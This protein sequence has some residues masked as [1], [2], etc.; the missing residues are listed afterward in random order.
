[1]S[2]MW[3]GWQGDEPLVDEEGT[4]RVVYAPDAGQ[5]RWLLGAYGADIEVTRLEVND[6]GAYAREDDL[7]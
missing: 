1:M 5:A 6:V 3:M 7:D 2:E 4:V